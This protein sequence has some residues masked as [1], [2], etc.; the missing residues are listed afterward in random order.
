MRRRMTCIVALAA[1]AG[2]ALVASVTEPL[3]LRQ[4]AAGATL[5]VRGSI[6]DV[7]AFPVPGRGIESIA[8][9]AVEHTIKGESEPFLAVRVPGGAIGGRRQITVGAPSLRVNQQAVFFLKRGPDNGW[10]P[11]GLSA[12]VIHVRSD[13]ATGRRLVAPVL[14]SGY[15]ASAGPVMRGDGRRRSLSVEEFEGL[16]VIALSIPAGTAE[17]AP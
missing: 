17:V 8:T 14:L 5:I 15:T 10:R 1:F 7:R 11:L 16:V 4:L 6:T 2:A 9:V 3:T 13:P 12:G